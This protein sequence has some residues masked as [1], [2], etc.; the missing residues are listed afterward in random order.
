MV[1][2]TISA[3][4]YV[5]GPFM[6]AL[7]VEVALTAIVATAGGI[8]GGDGC[9]ATTTTILPSSSTV[10]AISTSDGDDSASFSATVDCDDGPLMPALFVEV[11]VTSIVVTADGGGAGGGAV[12]AFLPPLYSSTRVTRKPRLTRRTSCL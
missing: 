1:T 6:P 9:S 7:F 2:A 10:V 5:D 11:A 8:V 4:G 12:T 3:A